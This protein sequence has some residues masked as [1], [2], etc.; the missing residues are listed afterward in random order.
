MLHQMTFKT[1]RQKLKK[2]YRT[3]EIAEDYQLSCS[4][5]IIVV[6]NTQKKATSPEEAATIRRLDLL[7]KVQD[8]ADALK[9]L[10]EDHRQFIA[11]RFG[12]ELSL[13]QAAREVFASV[14]TIHRF[15]IEV[16]SAFIV[17]LGKAPTME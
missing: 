1:A 10:P 11:L 2:Y 8:T 12:K 16:L 6:G 17:A 7:A 4:D 3:I 5:I 13:R 14:S 15:E 9:K